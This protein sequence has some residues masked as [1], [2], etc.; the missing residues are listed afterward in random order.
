MLFAQGYSAIDNTD[1]FKNGVW[2]KPINGSAIVAAQH[3][4]FRR[5][6][7][8]VY[9]VLSST[10]AGGFVQR[11]K[12]DFIYGTRRPT[13]G[14][15]N[16]LLLNKFILIEPQRSIASKTYSGR[17]EKFRSSVG[18]FYYGDDP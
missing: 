1:F 15:L 9:P 3:C 12:V 13:Y 2:L 14:A 17:Q 4:R 11:F 6:H 10:I 16:D 8:N 5:P 7:E 18:F